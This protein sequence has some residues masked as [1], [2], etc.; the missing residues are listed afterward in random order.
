LIKKV[1]ILG[2]HIQ[3]LGVARQI[4]AIGLDVLLFTD[5]KYSITRFSNA[6][7][8]TIFFKNENELIERI[9]ISNKEDKTVL[10]FPTNDQMVNFLS[11]NYH[12]L[13]EKFYLGIPEPKTVDIFFNKRRTYQFAENHDIPI[14]ASWYPNNMKELE[15]IAEKMNYPVIIKPAIMYSFHR[16]FRKKAFKCNNKGELLEKLERISSKIEIKDI[17]IQEFI[18]GGTKYLYSYGT[19]AVNGNPIA[20]IIANRIRQNPMDFGNSTTYAITCD[21]QEIRNIA[22]KILKITNYFGLAEL[23]FMYDEKTG[24]YKFLE[25]NTRSWKWHTISNGLGFSFIEKLIN[26]INKDDRSLINDYKKEIAWVERLSD[27]AVIAKEIFKGRTTIKK[28]ANS[29][30]LPKVHAVWSSKDIYPF[31]MYVIMSPILHFKRH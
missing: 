17:I 19:F 9:I 2:N 23:E 5:S 13:T 30:N 10:L 11:K 1:F 28:I 12:S 21:N 20:S 29:Y 18:G 27:F 24:N 4:K 7:K 6:V 14:P 31:F 25:V 26:Y 15:E 8:R 16:I 22:E 3:A